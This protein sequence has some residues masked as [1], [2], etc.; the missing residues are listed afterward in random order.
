[1]RMDLHRVLNLRISFYFGGRKPYF[2]SCP[3]IFAFAAG[4]HLTTVKLDKVFYYCQSKP[5]PA[6]STC[7]F[8]IGLAKPFEYE[9]KKSRCD[10][11]TV[12]RNFDLNI[13]VRASKTNV[14]LAAFVS[15][16]DS[17]GQQIQKD[18]L[19]PFGITEYRGRKILGGINRHGNSSTFC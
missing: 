5:K 2:E 9:W 11:K 14:D 6:Y 3:P 1:D 10:P 15:E 7:V 18:L 17:V 19:K 16:F 13:R 8:V 4:R 12:V